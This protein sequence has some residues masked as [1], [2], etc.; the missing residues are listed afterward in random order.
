MKQNKIG[1]IG[2]ILL[3]ALWAALT[4]GAWFASPEA[5]SES[6][7]RPLAQLPAFDIQKPGDFIGKFEEYTL[8][9]FPLRDSFRRLKSLFH[10]H[11]LNQ[12]DNNDI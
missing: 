9:Q 12:K 6:E 8:D 11:V 5:V 10:Y 2:C 3:L 1:S 7:R 4:F